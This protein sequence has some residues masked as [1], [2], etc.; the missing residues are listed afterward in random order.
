ANQAET[1]RARARALYELLVAPAREQMAGKTRL[2]VCPDGP[3]WSVPFQALRTGA[4]GGDRYLLE[5]HE[6][7]YAYSATAAQAALRSGDERR[8]GP[9]TGTLLV[10]A[11]PDFGG[12]ERTA[13]NAGR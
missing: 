4:A 10:F 8:A 5:E 12:A 11:N 3:L 13:N 1:Y 9:W 6:V 7:V 2:I